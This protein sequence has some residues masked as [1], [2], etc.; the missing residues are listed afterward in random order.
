MELVVMPCLGCGLMIQCK[1]Y[2]DE[3]EGIAI[4]GTCFDCPSAINASNGKVRDN[5]F[6][7][8]ASKKH[9]DKVLQ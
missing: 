2:E 3:K 9:M 4:V 6:L 5:P 8:I 7:L 1:K